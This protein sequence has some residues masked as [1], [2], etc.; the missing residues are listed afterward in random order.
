MQDVIIFLKNKISFRG[1]AQVVAHQTGG[2]GVA[3]SS[4][5]TPTIYCSYPF[6]CGQFLF[7]QKMLNSCIFNIFK[8][9]LISIKD[10]EN[11]QKTTPKL[12]MVHQICTKKSPCFVNLR[13]GDFFIVK[14]FNSKL[15]YA[16]GHIFSTAVAILSKHKSCIALFHFLLQ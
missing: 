3:S 15:Y 5:V 4:L 9:I 13:Q 16:L 6:G 12:K 8:N 14:Y 10:F 1:V 7:I 2:L 11:A